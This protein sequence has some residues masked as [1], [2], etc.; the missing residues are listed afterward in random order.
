MV[1]RGAFRSVTKKLRP[2]VTI[3]VVTSN[4]INMPAVAE[5]ILADGCADMVSLARPMLAD[6]HFVVKAEQGRVDE[7]NTCI[8][9]N[10]ACLDHTFQNK[11]ASCLVNPRACHETELVYT[12]TSSPKKIAVVGAGPAGLSYATVAAERGHKVTLFEASDRIGGQFNMAKEVP[13][14]EEFNETIRYFNR[15]LE[16][17]DVDV[18]LNTRADKDA[19]LA[20]GFDRV[21]LATGVIPR[22]TKIPGQDRDNVLSYVDVLL[23][24]KPVGERVAIIGAGGIGFDVA[25]YLAHGDH[26]SASLS[27]AQFLKEWGVDPD[28]EARGGIE[29]V[30]AEPPRSIREIVMFQRSQGKLGAKLG[31][32][33]GWIH[34]ATMKRMG[35]QMV[36]GVTYERI[37]DEGLWVH[38]GESLELFDVDT[39]V[40]CAG[41]VERRELQG[42]LQQAGVPVD[43]IG[44][45]DVAAEL[46]AKRAIDQGARL[47][48]VV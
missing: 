2:H 7:I 12:Q 24:K 44:G 9:C 14:K 4:R 37:D 43:L 3:P 35:I 28:N 19:L 6:S 36:A 23:H 22:E 15:Q 17:T 40:I 48:A 42:P 13:G 45:A 30:E 11:R 27:I 20:A 33:T 25:E 31:K 18:K 38:M 47:A 46:D 34:R 32:T 16:I 10:Q 29:G 21:V 26:P 8:G 5:E 41:Q 1:P 39:I